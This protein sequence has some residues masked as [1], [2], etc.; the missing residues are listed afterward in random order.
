MKAIMLLCLLAVFGCR[1]LPWPPA[2]VASTAGWDAKEVPARF[3][4]GL[5][6]RFELMQSV[7][8]RFGRMEMAGIGV[9]SV[10][11]PARSF[12]LA[13]M[14]PLGMKLFEVAGNGDRIESR[15]A[16]G[17]FGPGDQVARAVAED[18]RRAYFDMAPSLS[19][20]V[21]RRKHEIVYTEAAGGGVMEHVFSGAAQRLV[22]KRFCE[23]RRTT[24]EILYGPY[25]EERGGLIPMNVQI[26]NLL[27][28]YSL[29]IRPAPE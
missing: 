25:G 5:A 6:P 21:T 17:G 1:S 2:P 29:V 11:R 12:R 22:A 28:G 26:R 24:W 20:N 4:A 23:G 15:F 8:F 10:D 16:M 27:R 9:V 3:E 19:A 18:V 7:V 14:T 13:C